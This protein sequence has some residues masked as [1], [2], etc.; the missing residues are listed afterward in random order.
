GW[1]GNCPPGT[2]FEIEFSNPID[3]EK[4]DADTMVKVSPDLPGMNVQVF[5]NYLYVYGRGKQRTTYKVEV[6]GRVPD[7]FGQRLGKDDKLRFRVTDAQ[8]SLWAAGNGLVLLDPAAGPRLSVFSINH[9][10]LAVK[11]WKVDPGD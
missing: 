8:P 3:L 2:P 4:F 10:K 9:S 5:G 1:D 11:A 7:E 6:S